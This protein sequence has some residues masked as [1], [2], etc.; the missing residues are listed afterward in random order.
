MFAHPFS[1]PPLLTIHFIFGAHITLTIYRVIS[2]VAVNRWH[3]GGR[4]MIWGYKSPYGISRIIVLESCIT[5]PSI[6]TYG[7]YRRWGR[8]VA[9]LSDWVSSFERFVCLNL[10]DYCFGMMY[11]IPVHLYLR[12]ISTAGARGCFFIRHAFLLSRDWMLIVERL[13]SVIERFMH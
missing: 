7:P 10:S 3:N 5:S 13:K 9:F 12:S 1:H 4:P 6:F 2:S 8:G 11:N